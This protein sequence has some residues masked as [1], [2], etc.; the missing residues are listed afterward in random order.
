[1]AT[2]MHPAIGVLQTRAGVR[3]YAYV[4]G[5]YMEGSVA[6]LTAKLER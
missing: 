1:M 3:F 2:L 5:I 4:N 6:A